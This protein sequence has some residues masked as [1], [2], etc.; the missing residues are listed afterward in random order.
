MIVLHE[1]N[2]SANTT[3]LGFGVVDDSISCEVTEVLNGEYTLEMVYPVSG[4]RFAN[5]Q[6]RRVLLSTVVPDGSNLQ[7]FRIMSISKPLNGR[8]TV[9]ANH[10][11]YDLSGYIIAPV[12]MND[13]VYNILP[14]I[15][16]MP[17]PVNPF[18]PNTDLTGN[19]AF[20]NR[21][22]S[23][24]RS[25]LA[26]RR[27]SILDKFGG[28]FEWDRFTVNLWKRR[29]ANNG[30]RIEYAKNL[31]GLD[32]DT[33][34]S[35]VYSH[36]QAYWFDS[37]TNEE[38]HGSRVATGATGLER[39]LV[40]DASEDYETKPTATTLTNYATSYIS[41]HDLTAPTIS[42]S[43]NFVD[44][45]QTEEYKKYRN[46]EVVNLGDTV[47]VYHAGL[48]VN[49]TTR[50]RQTV[51]DV[52][53]NRFTSLKLGNIRAGIVDQIV[54]NN[55]VAKDAMTAVQMA[56]AIKN[57]T[58]KYLPLAGGTM[59]GQIAR[60]GNGGS[61]YKGRDNA[62]IKTTTAS[63]S[64][65]FYPSTSTKTPSGSWEIG[66]IGEDLAIHYQTDSDYSSN[67][68][69][70][71]AVRID[72]SGNFS[73][74][75]S[76]LAG[77]LAVAKGG[78]AATTAA[79]ARTNLAVLGTAGGTM[80]G[81]IEEAGKGGAYWRGRENSL[82]RMTSATNSSYFY[83][84]TSI[85]TNSGSWDVGSIGEKLVLHYQTDTDYGNETNTSA[86]YTIDTDGTWSGSGGGGGSLTL[87][88]PIADGGTAATTAVSALANL[89]GTATS[90]SAPT[91]GTYASSVVE[92]GYVRYGKLV[93]V[94][95]TVKARTTAID[96]T[97]SNMTFLMGLPA[98]SA[99]TPLSICRTSA[100]Y[101][102]DVQA[103][104]ATNGRINF[105]WDSG[106][107][108]Q[109]NAQYR[110]SGVYLMA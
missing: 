70:G 50:V 39:T 21:Y 65:L 74:T 87:P 23:S 29:G 77:T 22:N 15:F 107:Q 3:G 88:V 63:S 66:T 56:T 54:T 8:V 40:I 67:T 92:G 58:A 101:L 60:E 64:S 106:V 7:P 94:N 98:P 51:Y 33:D 108:M 104:V 4:R 47:A 14:T 30:V 9:R 6:V 41:T 18:T 83:P 37:E 97:G 2:Y 86:T 93:I 75:A 100:N 103:Y 53:R 25:C 96:G 59:V 109:A 91:L 31:T 19:A 81:Q 34:A 79:D 32:V 76:G 35:N 61:Y 16:S 5:L 17:S 36:V 62:E 95:L 12:I 72:S 99:A 45:S 48:G 28:E 71:T 52:L 57:E 68:N 84:M 105:L 10:I 69:T 82:T 11:S 73:G 20:V 78:T 46:L 43:A 55:I 89:F 38:S 85:K 1:S 42:I 44:L 49:I 110:L 27:G 24:I 26:G 13:Y 90:W 102:K 80:T